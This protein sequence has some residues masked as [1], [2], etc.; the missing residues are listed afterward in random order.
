MTTTHEIPPAELLWR[1]YC[2]ALQKGDAA[3]PCSDWGPVEAGL[4]VHG[5][6]RHQRQA[7]ETGKASWDNSRGGREGR[8]PHSFPQRDFHCAVTAPRYTKAM[9]PCCV[10]LG[11]GESRYILNAASIVISAAPR[12]GQGRAG[13]KPPSCTQGA[14][15]PKPPQNSSRGGHHPL[16]AHG[17]SVG[18]N[19]PFC[20]A[21]LFP[22]GVAQLPQRSAWLLGLF[23]DPLAT[24]RPHG[25]LRSN[26]RRAGHYSIQW[27]V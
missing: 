8:S 1:G 17:G 9:L 22:L 5:K 20:P 6:H 19:A 12:D 15:W 7:H 3:M 24:W 11:V 25:L 18:W 23:E 2:P 14:V 16:P 4:K 10:T 26:R 13:C 21:S 27:R